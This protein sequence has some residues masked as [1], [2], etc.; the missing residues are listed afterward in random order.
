[1]SLD[2][3][4]QSPAGVEQHG[5]FREQGTARPETASWACVSERR[6]MYLAGSPPQ[7]CFTAGSLC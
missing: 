3:P 2:Q 6:G 7:H 4:R 5:A 1:M